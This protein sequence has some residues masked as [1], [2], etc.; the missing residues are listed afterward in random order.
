MA[1]A[2]DRLRRR[3]RLVAPERVL[4]DRSNPLEGERED[5]V[6]R[7]YRLDTAA[8][9]ALTDELTPLLDRPSQRGRP[10]PILMQVLVFLR[11]IATGTFYG[12]LRDLPWHVSRSA[13][14][15]NIHRV[16][17]AVASLNHYV[18]FPRGEE[19]RTTKAAFFDVAGK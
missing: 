10:L 11:F 8:I 1:V 16:A 18:T 19:A 17:R 9:Y 13:I 3:A 5:H 4:C 7:Q 12:V 2:M 15:Q 6:H 14:C